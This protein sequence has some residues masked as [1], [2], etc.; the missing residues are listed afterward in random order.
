MIG[1]NK[2]MML[3]VVIPMLF[4]LICMPCIAIRLDTND[5]RMVENDMYNIK[6]F[7]I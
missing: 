1:E 6:D 4:M 2:Y 3:C 7:V 5:Y